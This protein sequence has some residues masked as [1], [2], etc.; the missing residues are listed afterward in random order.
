MPSI[1]DI[2]VTVP[3]GMTTLRPQGLVVH[4]AERAAARRR[5]VPVT[6]AADTFVDMARHLGLVD[7]VVLGDSLVQS[8]G[9]L[10]TKLSEA[11]A[12]SRGATSGWP[13]GRQLS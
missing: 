1:F 2:H 6:S 8:S 7:L 13:D 3:A 11:A 12:R 10:P 5:G 4:S 9:L